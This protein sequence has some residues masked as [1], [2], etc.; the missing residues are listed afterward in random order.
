MIAGIA[1]ALA[2]ERLAICG[3]ECWRSLAV[4]FLAFAHRGDASAAECEGISR[5]ALILVDAAASAGD[6]PCLQMLALFPHEVEALRTG[7]DDPIPH[8]PAC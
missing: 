3:P 1:E 7:S 8:L 4:D 5:T 6:A 2:T